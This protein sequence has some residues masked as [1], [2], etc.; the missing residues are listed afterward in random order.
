MGTHVGPKICHTTGRQLTMAF[1]AATA[2]FGH[3]GLE[4]NLLEE[5]AEDLETLKSAI[6]LH[7]KHRNLLHTGAFYRLPT[8]KVSNGVGVVAGDKAEA[9]YSFAQ[10]L[11]DPATSARRLRLPGLDPSTRYITKLIWPLSNVSPTKPSIV[12]AANLL[13]QGAVFSGEALSTHGIQLPSLLP[14]T[15]LIYHLE[16]ER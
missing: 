1:R 4:V 8:S 9:I 11:S 13:G 14:N 7:K 15:C 2:F 16:K 3:M 5:T 6:T 12:D 10:L